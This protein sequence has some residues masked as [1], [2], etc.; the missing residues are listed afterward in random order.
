MT[1]KYSLPTNFLSP[2]Q[3]RSYAT[4]PRCYELRYVEKWRTPISINLVLG[5]ALHE[6]L[7][8]VRNVLLQKK[9]DSHTPAELA[10][11]AA[12]AAAEAFE[13]DLQSRIDR[14]TGA[15]KT[16]DLSSQFKNVGEAKDMAVRI[17]SFAV[18][19][20]VPL[21]LEMGLKAIEVRIWGLGQPYDAGEEQ[22]Q[23]ENQIEPIFPFPFMAYADAMYESSL[24]DS[25]TAHRL[26]TPDYL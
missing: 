18:E 2:S 3:V 8:R 1:T 4:C 13:A 19:T 5:I 15:E 23:K 12:E 6:A 21:D 16:V 22:W 11:D 24:K 10:Q 9:L 25:K 20:L 26:L 14:E 17:A 7:R